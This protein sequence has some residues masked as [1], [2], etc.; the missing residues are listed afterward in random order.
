MIVLENVFDDKDGK[1]IDR[2]LPCEAVF[3]PE[4]PMNGT[5]IGVC[6]VARNN[7]NRTKTPMLKLIC[8]CGDAVHIIHSNVFVHANHVAELV[9]QWARAQS[10]L[11]AN[12]RKNDVKQYELI[13]A[14]TAGIEATDAM[15]SKS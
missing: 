4:T 10:W 11:D 5:G 6:V 9:A 15:W 1:F 12:A 7:P 8:G 14:K 13:D 3:F 2:E